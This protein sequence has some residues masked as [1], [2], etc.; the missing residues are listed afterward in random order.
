MALLSVVASGTVLLWLVTLLSVVRVTLLSVVV[1]G[2][3][4]CC[5]SLHCCLLCLVALLPVVYS[6]LSSVVPGGIDVCCGY[7]LVTLLFVV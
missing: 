5:V 2:T 4:V 6:A 1:S 3:V 7:R